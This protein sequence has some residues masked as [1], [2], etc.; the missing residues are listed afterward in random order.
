MKFV[1]ADKNAIQSFFRAEP[2]W[3]GILSAKDAIGQKDY[4]LL[5]SGPPMTGEKTTTTL[6]SAAVACVFEGWA[7]NFS[8]ADELIKSEKITFQPAQDYGVATPLAAVVS[9][10]ISASS[11]NPFSF[12]IA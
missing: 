10:S 12:S 4:T 9:P 1:D 8:E 2:A 11:S 3:Y 7:K 6:N 5:H